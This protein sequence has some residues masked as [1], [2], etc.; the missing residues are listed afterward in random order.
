M[1]GECWFHPH[2]LAI[3]RVKTSPFW[4]QPVEKREARGVFLSKSKDSKFDEPAMDLPSGYVKI[5]ME[6]GPVEIVDFPM[7]SMVI[8][9]FAILT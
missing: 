5:A 9:Q 8:F 6:N 7:K 2:S 1:A 4:L 3:L